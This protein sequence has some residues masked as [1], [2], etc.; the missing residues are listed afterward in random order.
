MK[1]FLNKKVGV[2]EIVNDK[3]AV[4]YEKHADL[5]ELVG[6]K[7]DETKSLDD[8]TV[9]ELKAKAKELDIEYNSDIKKDELI[10]LIK[11]AG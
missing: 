9:K 8:L 5:Y 3:L 6:D 11:N 1:R 4:Q 10:E 7:K 2:I